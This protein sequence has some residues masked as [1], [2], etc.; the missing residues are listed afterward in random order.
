MDLLATETS[1][2]IEKYDRETKQD[3]R[4]ELFSEEATF[5]RCFWFM[6]DLS[7]LR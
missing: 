5:D 3:G 6:E 7:N 1:I 4:E 2:E